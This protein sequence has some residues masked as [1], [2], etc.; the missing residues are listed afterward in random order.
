METAGL[1]LNGFAVALEPANLLAVLVGVVLGQII[2]ALPGVGPSLGMALL[3]P[4]SYG[5]TPVSAVV[6][7]SGIMY[8][9]TYGGKITSVLINKP[10]H[11]Y[12]II[13]MNE[14][15]RHA[16]QGPAGAA[17]SSAAIGCCHGGTLNQ[18]QLIVDA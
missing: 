18:H 11:S 8:G 1:L 6:L 16:R 5:R 3:S 17:P 12:E 4:V 7:V 15:H 14:G 13:T 10:V 9:A 2:G